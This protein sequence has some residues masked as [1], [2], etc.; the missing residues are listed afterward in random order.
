MLTEPEDVEP[1]LICELYLL[2]QMLQP[3][4]SFLALAPA[5]IGIDVGKGIKAQFHGSHP[6]E[7]PA[8]I[9]MRQTERKY[10][11]WNGS[12]EKVDGLLRCSR[13]AEMLRQAAES[14]GLRPQAE[15]LT[16]QINHF[17]A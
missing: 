8:E 1:D 14:P 13:M 5:W 10:K 6:V 9:R 16:F 2:D 4:R 11:L 15:R 3:L 12:F 7:F 17:T